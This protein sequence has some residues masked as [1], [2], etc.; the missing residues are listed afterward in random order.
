MGLENSEEFLNHRLP[1]LVDCAGLRL[2]I[3]GSISLL[4]LLEQVWNEANERAHMRIH[5]LL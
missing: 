3:A 5:A 4:P 2:R 1:V